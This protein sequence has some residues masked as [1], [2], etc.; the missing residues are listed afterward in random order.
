MPCCEL[1]DEI[2]FRDLQFMLCTLPQEEE[3]IAVALSYS[4]SSCHSSQGLVICAHSGIE[5]LEEDGFVCPACC[6]NHRIRITIE[7]VFN[8][9]L[10]GRCGCID[11]LP[12]N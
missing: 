1:V 10:V 9:I 4:F 11:L 5:I 6:R 2:P 12:D 8:L 7:R 3:A